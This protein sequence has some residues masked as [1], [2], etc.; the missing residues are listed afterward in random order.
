MRTG[1]WVVASLAVLA[2][3]GCV[4]FGYISR[5]YASLKPEVVT[6]GCKD[7]YEVYDQR[8]VRKMLIVSNGLREYA[9]CGLDGADPDLTR[10]RRFDEAAR[11]NLDETGRETCRITGQATF[12]EQK[13]EYTYTCAEPVEKPGTKVLRL[14]GRS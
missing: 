13:A 10:R 14:P 7:P 3:A 5:T 4:E 8:Q 6:I 12:D 2:S 9:G 11:T 1:L